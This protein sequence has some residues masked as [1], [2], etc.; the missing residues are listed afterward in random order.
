MEEN[1]KTGLYGQD[2]N[3]TGLYTSKKVKKGYVNPHQLNPDDIKFND[4]GVNGKIE[5]E[6]ELYSLGAL[7]RF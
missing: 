6:N 4:G 7:V 2:K 1:E 3:K 5:L